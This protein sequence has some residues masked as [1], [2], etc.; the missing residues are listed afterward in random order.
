MVDTLQ[1][2]REEKE[3]VERVSKKPTKPTWTDAS[4]RFQV[5]AELVEF[6]GTLKVTLKEADGSTDPVPVDK[7][8]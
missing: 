8:C 7:L 5:E 6:R 4:G 1:H 3:L 2:T